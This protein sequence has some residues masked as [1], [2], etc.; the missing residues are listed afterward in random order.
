MVDQR[1]ADVTARAGHDV[2]PTR[3]KAAL[4]EQEIGK[5]YRRQRGL[6]RRLEHDGAP[7]G[8]RRR[9]LVGDEIEREVERTDRADHADRYAYDEAELAGTGVAGVER[10]HLS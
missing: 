9:D 2:Q 10:H 6:T 1:V 8:D 7:R 4:V 5:P 3:R